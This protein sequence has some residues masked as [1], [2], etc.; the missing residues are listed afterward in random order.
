V[1]ELV[2]SIREHGQQIPA[3]LRP[4]PHED[5]GYAYQL[6]SGFRRTAALRELG[7]PILSAYVR[8]D[9]V[10]DADAFAAS[11]LE[12]VARRTYSDVDRAYIIR[13]HRERGLLGVEVARLMGLGERQMR[14][15]EALLDLPEAALHAL[16]DPDAPFKATHALTLKKLAAR[17]PGLVWSECIAL[18]NSEGLSVSQLTRRVNELYR[19]TGPR[20]PPSLFRADATDLER[21]RLRFN[22][23]RP[24]RRHPEPRRPQ[25]PRRRTPRRAPGGRGVA[26]R[27]GEG[28]P[29]DGVPTAIHR[30]R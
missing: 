1:P 25:A 28:W 2:R 7:A 26:G 22:P 23:R 18:V 11:V 8:R 30:P 10:T 21:G 3:V 17:H 19:R 13:R 4:H 24:G 5:S 29:A 14:N 27:G 12:N 9:L 15:L 16:S 6:V 20:R